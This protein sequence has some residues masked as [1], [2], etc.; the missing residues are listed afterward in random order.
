MVV[1]LD[2]QVMTI[3]FA[4]LLRAL[5]VTHVT[6]ERDCNFRLQDI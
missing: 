5:A 3:D 1:L 4:R 6:A 2:W